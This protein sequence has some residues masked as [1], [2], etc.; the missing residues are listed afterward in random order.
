MCRN[1]DGKEIA[2]IMMNNLGKAII[3]SVRQ[4]QRIPHPRFCKFTPSCS[5]YMVLAV[6]KYGSVKGLFKGIARILRCN[7]FSKGGDDYP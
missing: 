5:A 4:Y 2:L 3:F 7:P 6:E 1:R